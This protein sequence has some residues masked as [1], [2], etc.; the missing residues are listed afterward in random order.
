VTNSTNSL[1]YLFL[2][3][4]PINISEC[5]RLYCRHKV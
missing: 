3:S 2:M 1:G 4:R 5:I